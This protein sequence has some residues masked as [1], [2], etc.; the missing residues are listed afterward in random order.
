MESRRALAGV[1]MSW[2]KGRC[3]TSFEKGNCGAC[4]GGHPSRGLWRLSGLQPVN[5]P[6]LVV[7]QPMG[8]L[9][10]TIQ[11]L[12]TGVFR[13]ARKRSVRPLSHSSDLAAPVGKLPQG[14]ASWACPMR[15]TRRLSQRRTGQCTLGAA[16][17][18]GAVQGDPGR[19]QRDSAAV[20]RCQHSLFGPEGLRCPACSPGDLDH[21][22]QRAVRGVAARRTHREPGRSENAGLMKVGHGVALVYRRRPAGCWPAGR[23]SI[24]KARGEIRALGRGHIGK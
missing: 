16:V 3:R 8:S 11:A 24:G 7:C 20:C 2:C 1:D 17:H 14:S 4:R 6:A 21:L 18:D 13:S 15:S 5:A 9:P 22:P 12:G 10:L 19:L 23:Q